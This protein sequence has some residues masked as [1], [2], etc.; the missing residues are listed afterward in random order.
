[1]PNVISLPKRVSL[2]AQELYAQLRGLVDRA[3]ADLI[4]ECLDAG[5][6]ALLLGV[7]DIAQSLGDWEVVTALTE[8]IEWAAS[9]RRRACPGEAPWIE[10]LY[11]IPL[12]IVSEAGP[13]Y[14][15]RFLGALAP[16]Q[17]LAESF[18]A[19]G[20]TGPEHVVQVGDYLH[21]PLELE[22]LRYSQVFQL[23]RSLRS[24]SARQGWPD[25]LGRERAYLRFLLMTVRYPAAWE[26][27]LP[28]CPDSAQPAAYP[29]QLSAW[30]TS[31]PCMLQEVLG[32]DPNEMVLA[33]PPC[34]F[35]NALRSGAEAFAALQVPL[36]LMARSLDTRATPRRA[37]S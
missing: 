3:S 1:M 23:A 19:Y 10:E 13:R 25:G 30:T 37:L 35:F 17:A 6:D 2:A 22:R 15:A 12:L 18:A 26:A 11:A 24:A 31:A 28:F 16:R 9:H 27:T 14:H 33:R 29:K 21:H 8:E 4:S 34:P 20:L 36:E 7:L 32:L 5:N